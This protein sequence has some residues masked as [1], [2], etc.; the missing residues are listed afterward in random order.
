MS[1][2]TYRMLFQMP[3]MSHH[4]HHQPFL[5]CR[6]LNAYPSPS[7]PPPHNL[8]SISICDKRR[9][10]CWLNV[11]NGYVSSPQTIINRSSQLFTEPPFAPRDTIRAWCFLPPQTKRQPFRI[12]HPPLRH[13][14]GVINS[15]LFLL[16]GIAEIRAWVF[17]PG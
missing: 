6:I 16:V 12:Y 5:I 3:C 7:A 4:F 14:R 1:Y 8:P 2:I 15:R 10:P 13:V 17:F 11:R 9:H